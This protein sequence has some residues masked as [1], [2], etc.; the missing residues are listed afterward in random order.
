MK[1]T[2]LFAVLFLL[3][4]AGYGNSAWAQQVQ[5]QAPPTSQTKIPA[6]AKVYLAPMGGFETYLK[7]AM[8]GKKVPVEFVEQREQAAYEI[9]GTSESRKASSA[10]KAIM[11]D[12]RSDEEASI[13]ISNIQSGEVV[14][15]YSVHKQSSAHGQKS[16]A[17]ACAKH[18]KDEAVA[19]K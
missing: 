18:V 3:A 17:E 8:I 14:Y 11:W 5:N 15:A 6:G 7:T 12:W 16:T 4:A 10:K 19:T 1:N 9:T 2:K 13:K